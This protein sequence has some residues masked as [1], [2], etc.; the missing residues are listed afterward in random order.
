VRK[1][2]ATAW[3]DARDEIGAGWGLRVV[4]LVPQDGA[5]AEGACWGWRAAERAVR[6]TGVLVREGGQWKLVQ[7]HSS[8]AVP[9]ADIFG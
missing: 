6:I 9:N 1:R 8:I 4:R 3:R 7:S 2:C 5:G